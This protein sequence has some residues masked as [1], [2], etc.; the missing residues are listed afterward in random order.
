M[1]HVA[2][3]K[4]LESKFKQIENLD[5]VSVDLHDRRAMVKMDITDLRYPDDS[6]D[7]IYCSH[8]LI[9]VPN[10]RQAMREFNR[11]LKPNGFAVCIEAIRD[12]ETLEDPTISSP[13][14]Q[15]RI[16]GHP[17]HVR[18]YGLDFKDRLEEAG[19]S[20]KVFR[21]REIIGENDLLR[22]GVLNS[23]NKLGELIFFCKKQNRG[24]A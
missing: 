3:E 18:S 20:V 6:F 4:A 8:V 16:F 1:L 17:E 7:V 14:E 19:F 21:E 15:E 11:V 10:D 13:A 2:P 22:L 23:H 12:E 9:S 5:Y 24:Y